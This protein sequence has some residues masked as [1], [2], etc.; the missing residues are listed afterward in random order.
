MAK[1]K[2]FLQVLVSFDFNQ[3]A[4]YA[5]TMIIKYIEQYDLNIVDNT[6]NLGFSDEQMQTNTIDA[7][8]T[9]IF[10]HFILWQNEMMRKKR[11]C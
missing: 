7:H 5:A 8:F 4:R 11:A 3:I 6:F 9:Q 1:W 2:A 10:S